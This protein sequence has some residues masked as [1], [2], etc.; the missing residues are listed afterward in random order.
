M[1]AIPAA[2][3]QELDLDVAG[4]LDEALEDEPVVAECGQGFAAG[5]GEVGFEAIRR[6]DRAHALATATG[7]RLDEQRVA[8]AL[9]G[10]RQGFV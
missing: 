6:A 7:R 9:R 8:D 10:C 4:T 5:G 3:E 2:V 1:N